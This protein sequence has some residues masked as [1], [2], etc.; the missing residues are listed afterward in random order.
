MVSAAAL[1]V[2]TVWE[3]ITITQQAITLSINE[4]TLVKNCAQGEVLPE[5]RG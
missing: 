5:S 2:S 4:G 3:V 1:H